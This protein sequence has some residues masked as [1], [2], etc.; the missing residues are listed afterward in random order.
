MCFIT[1]ILQNLEFINFLCILKQKFV[2]VRA[3]VGWCVC[4]CV[5]ERERARERKVKTHLCP[6]LYTYS[7]LCHSHK[8]QNTVTTFHFFAFL[9]PNAL[10]IKRLIMQ[11]ST[12]KRKIIV[13]TTIKFEFFKMYLW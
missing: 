11:K 1:E 2:C 13:L 7:A 10:I 4:V 5:C 12:Q 6:F 3:C 9:K 8:M